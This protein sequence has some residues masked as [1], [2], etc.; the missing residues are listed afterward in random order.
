MYL[1]S[2]EFMVTSSLPR[3]L[4]ELEAVLRLSSL[5]VASLIPSTTE[6]AR[7]N[8]IILSHN[9]KGIAFIIESQKV[10]AKLAHENIF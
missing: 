2:R 5:A 1:E 4:L 6:L 7:R 3:L 10:F 8:A 9:R